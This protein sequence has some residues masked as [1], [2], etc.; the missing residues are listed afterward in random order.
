MSTKLEK[1][2]DTY[3]RDRWDSLSQDTKNLL[4]VNDIHAQLA[5]WLIWERD[6]Y[7]AKAH[8]NECFCNRAEG[9]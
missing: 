6:F 9:L 1:A 8:R 3:I 5:L 4:N 7:K 2:C